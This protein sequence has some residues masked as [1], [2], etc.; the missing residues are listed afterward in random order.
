MATAGKDAATVALEVSMSYTKEIAQ[1]V[2]KEVSA[3]VAKEVS[4]SVTKETASFLLKI[5]SRNALLV[6][7]AAGVVTGTAATL[8]TFYYLKR[9]E[10]ESATKKGLE[11]TDETGNLVRR[12]D[13]TTGGSIIVKLSC[14]TQQSVLQFVKDLK[15]NKIKHRLEEEFKKIGFDHELEITIECAKVVFQREYATR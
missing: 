8:G 2:I 6:A 5:G 9:L 1:S 11:S 10:S 3:S 15:E 7:F 12:V 13:F 14:Y 4:A